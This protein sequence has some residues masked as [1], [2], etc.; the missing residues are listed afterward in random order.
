MCQYV[1]AN[2]IYTIEDVI[3][4]YC[5]KIPQH[6]FSLIMNSIDFVFDYISI[7]SKI[8]SRLNHVNDIMNSID[9]VFDYISKQQ[10]IIS[11]ETR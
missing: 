2:K 10:N 4:Q 6:L 3:Y 5:N 11:T 1:T 9:F 8:L 7:N